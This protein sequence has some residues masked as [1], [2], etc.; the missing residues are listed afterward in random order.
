MQIIQSVAQMQN[1]ALAWRR[2]GKRVGLVPTM[3]FLHE[4]HLSLA[5]KA[6]EQN[7]LVVMSIFVNPIQFG[8]GEDYEVYPRDLTRDAALA[9]AEGVDYIFAP[10]VAEMYP[11]GYNTFVEV[12]GLTDTLCGASRPGHF[13]GVA[14]VV[15]KL[16]QIILPTTAY[17][18]QKDGQQVAVIERMVQDLNMPL[19]IVRVPIKREPD[20]LA[21]SSRNVYLAEAERKEAPVLYQS[22]LFAQQA[23]QK[24]E[25]SAAVLKALVQKS[26]KKASLAKIEY[27]ELVDASTLLPIEKVEDKA[28]LA[29]AVFFGST[30]LIDNI[31]LEPEDRK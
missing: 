3:G 22:L 17:F 29:L 14:T 4:G 6:K 5:Q 30:R 20:G 26:I 23:F 16:F 8:Q 19:S 18:G 27:V 1:L 28:M 9:E 7:D 12:F 24:G 13:K 21:M 15:T 10:Q 31:M 25:M 11:K 2:E